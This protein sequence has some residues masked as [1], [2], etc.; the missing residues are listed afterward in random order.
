MK[1]FTINKNDLTAKEIRQ[2]SAWNPGYIATGDTITC[3]YVNYYGQAC[4]ET[5]ILFKPVDAKHYWTPYGMARQTSKYI[6]IARHSCYWKLTRNGDIVSHG[7]K[8]GN[9]NQ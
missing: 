9:G 5:L 7:A 4:S 3:Q 8:D 6:I 2:Y 1:K